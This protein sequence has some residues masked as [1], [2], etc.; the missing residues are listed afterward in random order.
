MLKIPHFLII[1]L[2]FII[3]SALEVINLSASVR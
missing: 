1:L 2:C 3:N